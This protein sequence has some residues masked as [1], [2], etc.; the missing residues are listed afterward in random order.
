MFAVGRIADKWGQ[1]LCRTEEQFMPAGAI[2]SVDK[3]SIL[4][5]RPVDD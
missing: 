2:A 3:P 5:R 4:D 1:L